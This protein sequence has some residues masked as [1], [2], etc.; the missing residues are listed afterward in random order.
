M[1]SFMPDVMGRWPV[2]KGILVLTN[3]IAEYRGK[4]A[5]YQRQIP[6]VL[7]T[8]R[9]YAVIQST[10]SSNRIEGIV[11]P[12]RRFTSIMRHASEPQTR[13]EAEIA[14][15]RDVL[16]MIHEHHEHM[17]STPNLILQLHRDMM[18]YADKGGQ[19]KMADNYIEEVAPD[20]ERRI[21]FQTVPA[22]QTP[23]AVEE[24]CRLFLLE[25]QR[26]EWPDVLLIAA[27]VLDFLCIH[28][29]ADGNE[30]MARL[31]S[32]QLLYQSGYVVGRYISLERVI[33]DT[34]DQ[35]YDTLYRSSQGWH[36]GEHDLTPWMEYFLTMLL[37]AYRRFEQRVGDTDAAKHRGWKKERIQNVVHGFVADFSISDV[38]ELCPGISRSM[39]TR[40]LNELSRQGV[41]EC[42][43]KGRHARWKRCGQ[44][45]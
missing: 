12:T 31:L 38:E 15:Y 37:E 44:G 28:P 18:K 10:E 11:V 36:E 27:F 17:R 30:R 3:R 42:I 20:G 41:I 23:G 45:N 34:K 25:L 13:S 39:V 5:L 1:R 16:R 35:Y 4:Q 24:L 21:R 33:E 32:L 8:L 19:W 2:N 14:G 29:F 9:E 40:V 26:G 7:D 43:Q 6:Q 22:W